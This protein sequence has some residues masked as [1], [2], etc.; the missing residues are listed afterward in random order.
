MPFVLAAVLQPAGET[1]MTLDEI[2]R[3]IESQGFEMD[4]ERRAELR[5][6]LV[7]LHVAGFLRLR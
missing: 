7:Q 4:A 6:S 1:G 2:A 3:A 5:E